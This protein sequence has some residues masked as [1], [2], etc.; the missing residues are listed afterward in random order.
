[1][2]PI[3]SNQQLDELESKVIAAAKRTIESL[4]GLL[5]E[6]EPL[7]AFAH[8]KFGP[9]GSH[10]TDD[11]FLNLIEQVNQ[12]FTYLASVEAT[13]WL[14]KHHPEAIPFRLNLGTASGSDIE[15]VDG[16]IA[17]ETFAAVDPKNNH[18]LDRDIVKVGLTSALHKYVFYVCP[19]K[20][21][22]GPIPSERNPNVSVISL[23]WKQSST[24]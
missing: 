22:S 19:R 10:P 12:T 3:I 20:P 9:A 21:P 8:M 17:A 24:Q 15:S 6:S 7:V 4:R 16:Q 1:M 11:R 23:G 13:R 18:K 2:D 14:L 5:S